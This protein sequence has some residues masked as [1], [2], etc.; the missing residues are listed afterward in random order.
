MEIVQIDPK[1]TAFVTP[2]P[3]PGLGFLPVNA[4]LIETSGGLVLVD[5]CVTQARGEFISGLSSVANP[6]DIRWVWLTHPDRDHTGG[7][8][9]VLDA[10]PGARLFTTFTSVGHL[11]VGPEPIPLGRVQIVNPGDRVALDGAGVVA[12]RPPLFDNPGTVG[13]FD[14]GT[15][16]LVSSD[17]FGGPMPTSED[18]A[19]PDVAAVPEEQVTAGQ[20]IWGSADSPWVH[21]VDESKFAAEL[22]ALRTLDPSLILSAHLPAIH[23]NVERH[24]GVLS[25]LPS[26][27]PAVG[28]DQT[29]LE[30]MLAEMEA[31][32]P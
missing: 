7:L 14:P 21:S 29:V 2:V 6:S 18:A 4:F 30:A 12:L 23:G 15:R 10:A 8:R 32:A 1:V 9:E 22:H 13:F 25:R 26:S 5:T 27:P 3:I 20:L 16:I 28:P 31:A 17:C 11:L 24:L 19:V